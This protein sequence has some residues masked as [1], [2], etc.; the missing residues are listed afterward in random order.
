MNGDTR[1]PS[2]LTT[3]G[4]MRAPPAAAATAYNARTKGSAIQDRGLNLFMKLG[5]ERGQLGALA[6]LGLA[7][8]GQNRRVEALGFLD[9]AHAIADRL[10]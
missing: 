10:G 3:N 7:D 9:R 8:A 2:R 5:D 1:R 6:Q 4:F